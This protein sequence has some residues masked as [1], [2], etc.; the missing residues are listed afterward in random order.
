MKF[1]RH[2]KISIEPNYK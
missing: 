2:T 1:E